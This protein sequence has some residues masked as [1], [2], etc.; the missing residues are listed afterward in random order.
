M[1]RNKSFDF[2]SGVN[3]NVFD[4]AYFDENDDFLMGQT[5]D[6]DQDVLEEEEY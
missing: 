5:R 1:K 4:Y 2:P 6:F 3:F